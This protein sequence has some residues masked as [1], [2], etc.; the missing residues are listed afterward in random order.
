MEKWIQI[1][2]T[3]WAYIEV[4]LKRAERKGRRTHGGE[5]DAY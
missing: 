2:K 4:V 3:L 1:F 5:N